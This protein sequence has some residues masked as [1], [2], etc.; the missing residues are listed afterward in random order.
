MKNI[1]FTRNWAIYQN[2]FKALNGG[3]H[4]REIKNNSKLLNNFERLGFG[5]INYF[6]VLNTYI[7]YKQWITI[8]SLLKDF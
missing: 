3:E 7:L 8:I 1:I 5:N 6:Y 4:A 2:N